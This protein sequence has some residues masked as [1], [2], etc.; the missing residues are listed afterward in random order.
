MILGPDLQAKRTAIAPLS[1]IV[2]RPIAT[3]F[4]AREISTRTCRLRPIW[5]KRI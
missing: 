2:P 1:A 5:L 4:P 3:T